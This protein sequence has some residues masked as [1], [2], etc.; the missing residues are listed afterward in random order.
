MAAHPAPP[1]AEGDPPPAEAGG[2]ACGEGTAGE[3]RAAETDPETVA[4]RP[5]EALDL[6]RLEPWL[7]RRLDG[8]AGPLRVRQFA[9]G[10]ANLT[11][12]L[13]FGEREFVLRRPPLGPVAPSAHDMRREHRIL[14]ALW[15]VWPLAPRSYLLCTDPGVLGADFHILE[16][17]HGFV[18]RATNPEAVAGRPQLGRRIGA[19]VAGALAGLHGVDPAAAGLGDLGRAQ[20]F[21]ARQVAGWAKRWQAAADEAAPDAGA[22]AAWLAADIPAPQAARLVHGDYKLDNLLVSRDDPA[23]PVA[24]LDWDMGTLGDP[25]FD[26][27]NLLA[28]WPQADD[29]A[30]GRLAAGG[31]PTAQPGFPSRAALAQAYAARSGFDLSRFAWYEAFASFRVAVILQQI[32]IRYLRG[33]TGDRRFAT[34]APR[35]A[36]LIRRSEALA[37]GG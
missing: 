25:L 33:Q 5:G 4:A 10:H 9:G 8:A 28:Y 3:E 35:I 32:Y 24:L 36:A 6:A 11:Y 21:A 27:A 1:A 18:L 13:S 29:G 17:R 37:G 22:I 23:R 20:G 15:R 14:A 12:L 31:G 2:G 26:L 34:L 7:R 30:E 19:A 16:R